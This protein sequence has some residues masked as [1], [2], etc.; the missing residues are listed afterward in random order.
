MKV[1]KTVTKTKPEPLGALAPAPQPCH[2]RV[3]TGFRITGGG[4]LQQGQPQ[5]FL[6]TPC[7]TDSWDSLKAMFPSHLVSGNGPRG[8]GSPSYSWIG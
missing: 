3:C 6:R 5:H 8:T 4:G 1:W 2:L 7:L